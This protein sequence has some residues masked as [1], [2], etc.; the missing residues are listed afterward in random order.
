[1]PLRN[2]IIHLKEV[3][4]WIELKVEEWIYEGNVVDEQ[5]LGLVVKRS[6]VFSLMWKKLSF[7]ES[8]IH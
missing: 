3:L 5:I 6:N 7:K 8:L 1:M 4:R 2:V